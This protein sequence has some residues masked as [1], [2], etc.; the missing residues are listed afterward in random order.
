[1][2]NG[3]KL[4]ANIAGNGLVKASGQRCMAMGFWIVKILLIQGVGW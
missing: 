3:I 4:N 2:K 1:M